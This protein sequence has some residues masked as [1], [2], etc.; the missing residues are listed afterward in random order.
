MK[1]HRFHTLVLSMALILGAGA[2]TA[3]EASPI[4]PASPAVEQPAV[5]AAPV[6]PASPVAPQVSVTEKT[7]AL[8]PPVSGTRQVDVNV[9]EHSSEPAPTSSTNWTVFGMD[10]TSGVMIGIVL[11]MVFVLAIV[12]VSRDE[13]TTVV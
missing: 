3:Q 13:R 6:T 5:E 8:P 2:A 7:E 11:M 10:S 1:A 9:Q 12:A 4:P